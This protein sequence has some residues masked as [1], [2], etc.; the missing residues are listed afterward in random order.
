MGQRAWGMALRAK[1]KNLP[2]NAHR[3][4]NFNYDPLSMPY[5]FSPSNPSTI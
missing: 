5:A 3:I 1:T 4:R 2:Q